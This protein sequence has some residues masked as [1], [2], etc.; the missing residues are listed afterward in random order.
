MR[1]CFKI[2]NRPVEID[3]ES[4]VTLLDAIRDN[5]GLTGTHAGCEHGV[6]GACT[7]IVDSQAVRSCLMLAVQADDLEI[8]TVE[9]PET[10]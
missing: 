3:T 2:N 8:Q 1:I 9:G 5:L 6:C 10:Q 4:R 7:V